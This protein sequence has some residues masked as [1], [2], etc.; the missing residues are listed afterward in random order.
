MKLLYFFNPPS[1][2]WGLLGASPV[3]PHPCPEGLTV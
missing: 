1:K 2:F 3:Q